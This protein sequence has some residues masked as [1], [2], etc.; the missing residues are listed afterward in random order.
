MIAAEY[1]RLLGHHAADVWAQAVDA[2]LRTPDRGR[3]FP[4]I[5]ELEALMAPPTAERRKQLVRCKAMLARA[6]VT[7]EERTERL[8]LAERIAAIAAAKRMNGLDPNKPAGSQLKAMYE[9]PQAQ[10]DPLKPLYVWHFEDGSTVSATDRPPGAMSIREW[11][12]RQAA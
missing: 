12:E 10:Q 3:W 7:I 1:A 2:W 5:S 11:Q 9:P 8:P 4:T 6:S